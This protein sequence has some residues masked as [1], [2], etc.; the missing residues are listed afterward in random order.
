MSSGETKD[1]HESNSFPQQPCGLTLSTSKAFCRAFAR[2]LFFRRHSLAL[3]LR[4]SML[5]S[6]FL[7]LFLL[8]P[9][10]A[11]FFSSSRYINMCRNSCY[12]HILLFHLAV[13]LMPSFLY[14]EPSS[15]LRQKWRNL[16]PTSDCRYFTPRHC[17]PRSTRA[18]SHS[19]NLLTFSRRNVRSSSDDCWMRPTSTKSRDRL[20][21][22]FRIR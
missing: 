8:E 13:S 21:T 11:L 12:N 22:Y 7:L 18:L 16:L 4:S 20:M 3:L 17:H 19:S 15:H 5:P 2:S 9:S 6:S 14:L 1:K 10:T